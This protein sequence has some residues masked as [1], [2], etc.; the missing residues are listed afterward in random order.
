MARHRRL[1]PRGADHRDAIYEQRPLE[2]PPR[3]GIQYRAFVDASAG[4][5]DAFCIGIAHR[6]KDRYIV[7][8]VRGRHPPFDPSTVAA[9]FAALAKDYGCNEVCGDN[10]SGEWVVQAFLAAGTTYRCSP[11]PK[12]G[13][14]LEG[15]PWFSARRRFDS[16]RAA[17]DSRIAIA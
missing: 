2:L 15:L 10:F 9:E 6:E 3:K 14:Y 5:H 13:L 4:R 17:P 11:L 12:S 7:D 1:A 16:Q 8:V